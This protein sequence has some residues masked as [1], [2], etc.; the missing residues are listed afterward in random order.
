MER[1][2][3]CGTFIGGDEC[4]PR[5]ARATDIGIP[6]KA[7]PCAHTPDRTEEAHLPWTRKF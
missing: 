6:M 5:E 4:R 2:D 7:L 3:T 1:Q